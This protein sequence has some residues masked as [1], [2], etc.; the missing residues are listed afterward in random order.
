MDVVETTGLMMYNLEIGPYAT[1]ND[2]N[3]EVIRYVDEYSI[4]IAGLI[5]MARQECDPCQV[6]MDKPPNVQDK[7]GCESVEMFNID[8]SSQRRKRDYDSD[9]Y[10]TPESRVKSRSVYGYDTSD[11]GRVV[12]K[13]DDRPV[14][15]RRA[16][17]PTA[18]TMTLNENMS[19][20]TVVTSST[21]GLHQTSSGDVTDIH[22]KF[23][24][25]CKQCWTQ[26]EPG[27]SIL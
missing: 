19:S 18:R 24:A 5:G 15:R 2:M 16:D 27:V 9:E 8:A 26:I 23:Y 17:R 7:E 6:I 10:V 12:M 4:K 3:Q 20:P 21:D 22:P 11:N 1:C 25:I 14:D 13:Y